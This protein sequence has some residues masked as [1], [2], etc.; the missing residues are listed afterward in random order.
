VGLSSR[1][2]AAP[3]DD[4]TVTAP[5][6][7]ISIVIPTHN[8]RASVERALQ[9]L[10]TQSYPLVSIEVIV[11]A[12]GCTDG[13]ATLD[14][15]RWPM[16]TRVIERAHQGPGAA[17]NRGAETATGG[18]LIF[19]DDDVEASRGLVAAHA[20]AHAGDDEM[21][22]IG[23]L[24]PELQGRQDLF[25][26]MLRAW[27]EAMFER[28]AANGHRFAYS[29]LLSGNFSVSRSLFTR[30]GGFDE[31]LRC[32]EDYELGLRLIAAG[33]RL[34]FFPEA[35][36][37]H[38]EH[39]T[40]E[41]S[42]QRKRQEGLADVMLARRYPELAPVLP[43]AARHPHLTHRGRLL[44][45]LAVASPAAG[46]LMAGSCRLMLTVLE[47]SR[48]R[49]RWRRLLDDLLSYWYWRGVGEG[50]AGQPP[51][52]ISGPSAGISPAACEL[53]LQ[54]GLDAAMEVLDD[55]RPESLR[56]RWGQV[57]VG[58]LEPHPGAEPL[59]GRHLPGLLRD[60]FAG[61][62]AEALARAHALE[63]AAALE[64]EGTGDE[65]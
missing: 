11:V 42:L 6:R 61:A 22:A 24:P 58:E 44:R 5:G 23:Y 1:A 31:T 47:R 28:M 15:Q 18:L 12:D 50:L 14:C 45:R 64:P 56:L 16:R 3:R 63:N 8:R 53:D 38:H 59:Q 33:A 4:V 51:E 49:T 30:I 55:V 40:L 46:D 27:W 26:T 21:V 43:L 36:G 13:T 62:F 48:L 25:A 60:R 10:S 37:R 54:M 52:T 65:G 32:H 41:R 35:A 57:I 34:R 2:P 7:D 29:D 39:T 20:R 19:L 17:R 9:A